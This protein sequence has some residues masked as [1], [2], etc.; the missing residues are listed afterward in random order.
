MRS[1]AATQ[2]FAPALPGG[3][4]TPMSVIING[5][6]G[7]VAAF[8]ANQARGCRVVIPKTGTLSS[9]A[10]YL[11]ASSGNFDVG[12]YSGASTRLKLWTLGS[13]A[14]SGLT[15]N[16]WNVVGNPAL[17]VIQGEQYDFS[18]A[19]DN[20]TATVGESSLGAGGMGI[21]PT[22]YL[23]GVAAAPKLNWVVATSFPLPASFTEAA[24]GSSGTG[25]VPLILALV[26]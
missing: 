3:L 17:S 16:A 5:G 7:A 25:V 24:I 12:V 19:I 20:A 11:G 2:V 14:T 23:P 21:L 1:D 8:T 18:I 10:I 9:I 13:T 4:V 22:G 6:S 15:A 26:T